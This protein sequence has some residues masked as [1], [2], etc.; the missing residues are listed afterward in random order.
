MKPFW[1]TILREAIE[2]AEIREL[3]W[4]QNCYHA[5]MSIYQFLIVIVGRSGTEMLTNEAGETTSLFDGKPPDLKE[6]TG[7]CK[8][9]CTYPLTIV[10]VW[11][12]ALGPL[13]LME[14][15]E[16]FRFALTPV[17]LLVIAEWQNVEDIEK[18]S[19]KELERQWDT[20]AE[21]YEGGSS[22]LQGK[23]RG[24][25]GAL[26]T[27]QHNSDCKKLLTLMAPSEAEAQCAALCKSESGIILLYMRNARFIIFSSLRD[28]KVDNITE[29][30]GN[31][32]KGAA[33]KKSKTGGGRKK[34]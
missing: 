10:Y 8:A 2:G 19:K 25:F 24:A 1:R 32:E 16:P 9:Y 15:M 29:T 7:A 34:K 13:D 21:S 14:E 3:F 33:N 4:P 5:S 30:T 28:N 12:M 26:V 17:L 27:Q 11:K 20:Q 31:A 23:K 18:F 22:Y 6:E